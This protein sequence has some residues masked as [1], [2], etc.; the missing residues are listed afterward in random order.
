MTLD[1]NTLFFHMRFIPMNTF[2]KALLIVSVAFTSSSAFAVP[3]PSYSEVW[4]AI[5]NTVAKVEEA[6]VALDNGVEKEA[7]IDMITEARQLQKD[8]A[9]NDL[10]VKRNRASAVLKKARTAIKKDDREVAK[11]SIS[12]ALN[13]YQ[14]IKQLYA[15]AH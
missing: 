11:A 1:A 10:D 15:A 8:I 14:E 4:E 3:N 6:K 13:R 2:Y 5:E 12:E 9:N 7:L